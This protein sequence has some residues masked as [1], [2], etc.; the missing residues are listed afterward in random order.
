MKA[1]CM[2]VTRWKQEEFKYLEVSYLTLHERGE[3]RVDRVEMSVWGLET[4]LERLRGF[5]RVQRRDSAN[6]GQRTLHV[7]EKRKA[8]EEGHDVVRTCRDH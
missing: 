2:R 3:G 1:E 6:T 8:T 5:G 7:E 4:R